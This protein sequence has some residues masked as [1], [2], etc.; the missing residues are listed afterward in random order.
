MWF[1]EISSTTPSQY[2][3]HSHIIKKYY[4]RNYNIKKTDE[5]FDNY[6]LCWLNKFCC[7]KWPISLI[8][9]VRNYSLKKFLGTDMRVWCLCP[10]WHSMLSLYQVFWTVLILSV[11][12]FSTSNNTNKRRLLLKLPL[13]LNLWPFRET[14]AIR[15][16]RQKY[17]NALKMNKKVLT[18]GRGSKSYEYKKL[19]PVK[20]FPGF[21]YYSLGY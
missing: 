6:R 20:R 2:Y 15:F 10:L 21:S 13:F 18:A 8:N 4:N 16:T 17:Q 7:D 12:T 14:F 9:L 5:T 1:K 3:L 11:P 19:F